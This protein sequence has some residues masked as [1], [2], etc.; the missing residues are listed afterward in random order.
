MDC[1][2][3]RLDTLLS[4]YNIDELLLFTLVV[5]SDLKGCP[6]NKQIKIYPPTLKP[7]ITL[8]YCI[9]CARILTSVE[10]FLLISGVS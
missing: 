2:D 1:I 10:L 7:A 9:R 8:F 3:D 4:F 6:K 5:K